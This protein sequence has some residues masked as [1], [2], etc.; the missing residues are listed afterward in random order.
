MA[1]EASVN[2]HITDTQAI[3]WVRDNYCIQ[4]IETRGQF[5]YLS[6]LKKFLMEG[7]MIDN[8]EK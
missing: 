4:A 6:D 2:N 8:I 1:Y 5:E 3:N 7:Q